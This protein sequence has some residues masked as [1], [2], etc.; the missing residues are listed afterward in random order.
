MA[1]KPKRVRARVTVY[2][3]QGLWMEARA[4]SLAIGA[5]GK[6]P[7][8]LSAMFDDALA[9]ELE[10]LRRKHNGSR[11]WPPHR[12]RLPGGRPPKK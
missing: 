3:D 12:A 7:A 5:K 4:A 9:R 8:T 2:I 1:E 11:P 10:R 6:E